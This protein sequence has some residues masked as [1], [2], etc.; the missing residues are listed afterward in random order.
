MFEAQL[1]YYLNRYIGAYVQGLDTQSLKISVFKGDVVLRNLKLKPEALADLNLPIT[2][3]AG[4]LGSLTLKVPWANLGRSPVII[5]IDRLYILAGPKTEVSSCEEEQYE[6]EELEREA[7]RR[8]V[9]HAE[10]TALQ[11]KSDDQKGGGGGMFKGLIDTIIGNLQLSIS[12]IHVRYEDDTSNPGTTFAVGLTLESLRAHTVDESG[13]EAFVTQNPMKLLRK[14]SELRRL[15]LY[16]D[17]GTKLW[18]PEE[19]WHKLSLNAWDALFRAGIAEDPAVN[20]DGMG[21]IEEHGGPGSAPASYVL[22]PVD[23]RLMYLRRGREVR[24]SEDDAIQEAD[25]QLE[26]LSLHLSRSQYQSLQKLLEA[27]SSLSARA[28]NRYLRPSGRPDSPANVRR[29]WQY[30]GAVVR[31]QIRSQGFNWRQFEKAIELR[32]AY[33]SQYVNCLQEGKMGGDEKIWDMDAQLN[34]HTTLVFRKLAHAKVEMAKKRAA[35]QAAAQARER[36]S[37]KGWLSWAWGGGG[38]K[39]GSKTDEEAH[40]DEDM[41]GGLNDEEQEALRDLVSEQED[42]LVSETETPWSLRM[43]VRLRVTSASL[44]LDG[45][46]NSQVMRAGMEGLSSTTKLYP[47]TMH[48]DIEVAAMGV[49]APE[50][51]LVRTGALL[52]PSKSTLGLP[53]SGEE[54]QEPFSKGQA[55]RL[56]FIQHPQDESTDA[57]V[58]LNLAPSYVTYNPVAVQ[59][60]MEFFKTEE[61]LDFSALG[62]Q[63]IAQVER[64][65]RAARDQLVA[66]MNHRPKLSVKLEL[67]GPKVAIPVP[68]SDTEG[69]LTLVLDLGS[70][71]VESD[72][73]LIAQLPQEEAALYECLRLRSRDISAYVVD[74]EFSFQALEQAGVAELPEEEDAEI[75]PVTEAITLAV[76]Q[77]GGRALGGRAIFIP[78]LERCGTETTVQIARFP[79]PQLPSL[80]A[81]LSVPQLRFFISPARVRR[82]LRVLRAAMPGQGK[83]I[84]RTTAQWPTRWVALYR[85]SL[86]VLPK[87]DANAS[88]TIHN[89]WT[90]RRV[91]KL[92]E[93]ACGGAKHVLAICLPTVE[94]AHAVQDGSSFIL[95]FSSDSQMEEWR[96]QLQRSQRKMKE[97]AG[98]VDE[99]LEIDFDVSAVESETASTTVDGA[100]AQ[101][102]EAGPKAELPGF[103]VRLAADLGEFALFVSGRTA[104]VWWP[105][106]EDGAPD[107]A[108]D[109]TAFASPVPG[110]KLTDSSAVVNVEGEQ[111][112]IVIRASSGSTDLS[113]GGGHFSTSLAVGAFEIEDL[114]VGKRCPDHG[115]LARSFVVTRVVDNEG[116]EFYDASA[117]PSSPTFLSRAASKGSGRLPFSDS[118]SVASREGSFKDAPGPSELWRS[119]DQGST[120]EVPTPNKKSAWVLDFDTWAQ[121]S[122][123]YAGVDA[124][125]RMRLKTLYFYANRPTIGALMGIGGD[126]AAAFKS[127]QAEAAPAAT[128]QTADTPF[129]MAAGSRSGTNLQSAASSVADEDRRDVEASDDLNADTAS[130]LA[131]S[132][133]RSESGD[134]DGGNL[135]MEGGSERVVFRLLVE[136]ER[137]EASL[138]YE[139]CSAPP[140]LLAAIEDVHF[141]LSVHPGTLLINA[142]LGNMRAQDGALPEGHPYRNICDLRHG[143]STSLIELEFAS[144]TGADADT[145]PR[146]PSGLP[147]YTLTAQLRE[148]EL[149]FLNRFL[150]E[151]LRYIMLLLA[152][153]PPPLSPPGL[154]DTNSASEDRATSTGKAKKGKPDKGVGFLLLLDVE[155][156]APVITIPRNTDSLDALEV[157]LGTFTLSN[158]IAWIGG[159]GNAS[160]RKAVL[161]EE[162]TI[163]LS[164]LSA[165]MAHDGERGNNM[166]REFDTGLSV[167]MQRPIRDLLQC[168]PKFQVGINIPSIKATLSDS[169]YRFIT[170]VAGSNFGEPLRLPA[171]AQWLEDALIDEPMED[172]ESEP[173]PSLQVSR[174]AETAIGRQGSV[175]AGKPA[176]ATSS[177]KSDRTAIRVVI[178]LGKSELEM[179]RTSNAATGALSPLARFTI[180]NLWVA[181]R[182]TAGGA[183]YLSVSLPRVEGVDLR[184]WVP[185]EHSLVISSEQYSAESRAEG[186]GSGDGSALAWEAAS[187]L[188]LEYKAAAQMS[189]QQIR[190]RLQRPTISAEMSFLLAVV[191]FY[192]PDFAIGSITPVPF[193]TQDILLTEHGYKPT[194]DLWLSPQTRLLADSPDGTD[195]VYDGQG[196][197]LILPEGISDGEAMPVIIVGAGKTLLLRDVKIVHAESLP[198]C[199]QLGSGGQL[200]ANPENKVQRIE[201]EDPTLASSPGNKHHL[202]RLGSPF[203]ASPSAR[204][205][206]LGKAISRGSRGFS[207]LGQTRRSGSIGRSGSVDEA[208][209]RPKQVNLEMEVVAVGVGLRFLELEEGKQERDAMRL[210]TPKTEAAPRAP[211]N[212]SRS[213]RMLAAYMDLGA[214]YKIA[215]DRQRASAELRGLHVETQVDVGGHKGGDDGNK[216]HGTVLEPCKVGVMMELSGGSGDIQMKLSD[217]RMNLSPDV[218][219]LAM[220]LQASV[221]EP[222]V[223]PAPDK[224][225]ARCTRFLQLWSNHPEKSGPAGAVMDTSVLAA[226][227]GLTFWRP[228]PPIGYA[229]LGDCVTTGTMQPTFQVV[230]VAVNSGLVSYPVSYKAA[231]QTSGLTIWEPVPPKGYVALGCLAAPG[232]EPPALTEMVTVHASIGVEAPLG[233]C[234]VLKEEKSWSPEAGSPAGPFLDLRSPLGITPAALKLPQPASPVVTPESSPP[235]KPRRNS[236]S[237]PIPLGKGLVR[238]GPTTQSAA[239]SLK[240]RPA[241]Y[242]CYEEFQRNRAKQLK[243]A[244]QRRLQS[245]AVD[246][247][248]VWWDKDARY[249][250]KTGLSFWRPIPPQGYISLGDCAEVGYD[251]P[252]SIVVLLDSELAE[253][254]HTSTPLVRPPRGFELLWH[255]ESDRADRCLSIWRPV[256]FPGYIAMGFVVGRGPHPPSRNAMRCMRANE[257]ATVD[258]RGTRASACLPQ[259][260]RRTGFSVWTGDERLSTFVVSA[261]GTPP[262]NKELQRLKILDSREPR[263]AEGPV[264]A[265]KGGMNIVLKT[266][267]TS[268]LLRDALRRP[269]AEIE[270][271][272]VDASVRRID[273]NVTRAYMGVLTSAWSYNAVIQAWEP[274]LEPWKLIVKMDMNTSGIMAHGVAPGANVSVK[275]T[276]ELM[277]ITLAYAAVQSVF[278]A[279]RQ[280]R[281]LHASGSDEAYKRQL[282]AADAASVHTHV[283]NTLGVAAEMQLDFGSHVE[284]AVLQSGKSTAVLQPLPRPPQRHSQRLAIPATAQ[285]PVLLV[286][287]VA[288]ASGLAAVLGDAAGRGVS[289]PD[290]YLNLTLQSGVEAGSVTSTADSWGART[291]AVSVNT[292]GREKEVIETRTAQP[293]SEAAVPEGEVGSSEEAA[294]VDWEEVQWNERLIL[295]LPPDAEQEEVTVELELWDTAGHRAMGVKIASATAAL[296]LAMFK[297]FAAQ[298]ATIDLC[299]QDGKAAK[300]QLQWAVVPQYKQEHA[301]T[302]DAWS[303]GKSTAGQRALR[304]AGAEDWAPVYTSA[305]TLVNSSSQALKKGARSSDDTASSVVPVRM[306]GAVVALES[307]FQG[308]VK[309]EVL[310]S[311]CQL[312][313]DTQLRLEVALVGDSSRSRSSSAS[314]S[315]GFGRQESMRESQSDAKEEEI[316]ENERFL[317]IKGWG[318]SLPT[319]RKRYSTRDGS[320]S[321]AE[322]PSLPLPQGWEWEGPWGSEDWAYGADWSTIT[323]PPHPNSLK[324]GMMDF[325]RRRRWVRRRRKQAISASS[326]AADL[327]S[328]PSVGALAE[329]ASAAQDRDARQVLGIAE[330]GDSLPVPHGWRSSGK[331]LVVRPILEGFPDAH[332]W[333][334]GGSDGAHSVRLDTLDEGQTRLLACAPSSPSQPE[335]GDRSRAA[336]A[337]AVARRSGDGGAAELAAATVWISATVEAEQLPGVSRSETLTDWRIVVAPPLVL[338]NQLPLRGSFLVWERPKEGENLMLRQSGV[339]ASGERRHIYAA[340]MRREVSLQFYPDGFEWV[341]SDPLPLSLGYSSHR[342]GLDGDQ[343]LQDSFHVAR[344]TGSEAPQAIY[345]NRELDMD[346]WQLADKK[347]D[348]GAAVALGAPLYVRMFVPLWVVNATSL[349][350]AA[351]VV[352]VQPPRQ[353]SEHEGQAGDKL[354]DAAESIRLKVLETDA[355]DG[356]PA[357]G[358][359]SRSGMPQGARHVLAGSVSMVAYPMQQMA[360]FRRNGGHQSYGLRLK[361]GE[362]GWTAPL[363]LESGTG[364]E[365]PDDINT[366]PV[367]IRARIPEW[368]TVHEIVAR[369]ELVG[370]GFERTLAL[371]L[372]PQLVITNH[373]G[374][375]LQLAQ[376]HRGGYTQSIA[377]VTP[378]PATLSGLPRAAVPPAGRGRGAFAPGAPGLRATVA[379]SDADVTSTLDLPTGGTGIPLHWSLQ[380]DSRAVCFRFAPE[381]PNEPGPQWSHPIELEKA[382]NTTARFVSLPGLEKIQ[383]LPQK[384]QGSY[385]RDVTTLQTAAAPPWDL[386]GLQIRVGRRVRHYTRAQESGGV[387][388]EVEVV[389]LRF[390]NELRAPGCMHVILECVSPRAPYLLENRSGQA[391]RYRQSGISDLPYIPLPAFSAASFAWQKENG[392]GTPRIEVCSA[393][394]NNTPGTCCELDPQ[395]QPRMAEDTGAAPSGSGAQR[396][397]LPSGTELQIAISD[398]EQE[399]MGAAGLLTIGGSA[400]VG[401]GTLERVLRVLPVSKGSQALA[402]TGAAAAAEDGGRHALHVNLDIG[403]L[404][405][406]VVDQRPEELIAAAVLGVR[407]Q[408]AAGLGPLGNCSSLRFSVDSMQF[409]NQIFGS[410]F[411][412]VMC[413]LGGE[414]GSEGNSGS[415]AQPLLQVTVVKQTGGPRGQIYYP[416]LSFRVA[417]TLQAAIAE[418]LVWR[419]VEMVQRLDLGALSDGSGEKHVATATDTPVQISLV[420]AADLSAAVSFRGDPF[421]RPRWASHMGVMSWLLDMANFEGI[422]VRLR[423]FEMQN[424]SMLWSAFIAQIIRQIKGQVAGV[425]LSFITNFGVFSGASGVLGALSRGVASLGT[426]NKTAEE[427]AAARQQRSIGN[428]GEGFAEGGDALAQGFYRGFTGLVTKP[429]QGARTGVGG[430]V[431][432]L[433]QGL[434]GVAAQPVSGALDFMSS[435]F[436]GID[437]SSNTILGKLSNTPRA[438]R[439]RRLPRSIGGDRKLQ[440]FVRAGTDAQARMEEVGQALM[441]RAV[442]AAPG[443]PRLGK[444]RRPGQA[445]TDAYEEHML[446]LDERVA[447]MTNQRLMLL[448]APGFQRIH[449]AAKEGVAPGN[450]D[451]IPVAEIRWSVEWQDLL[452]LE[453]RRTHKELPFYDRITVHRKGVPGHEED[454]PLAHELRCFPNESQADELRDI[455]L[456]VRDKFCVEP[457][458]ESAKWA[459][460]HR[461]DLAA[462]LPGLPPQALPFTMPSLDFRLVWHTGRMTDNGMISVW[463]VVA[464]PGY[465]ALGDV[466]SVGLDP[467]NAP[468]Q[469]YRNDSSEKRT[470][471][472]PRLAH[473]VDF[474]LVFRMNG[475]TPVTMWMP[476]APEGYVAL[477]T[478]VQG[479]PMMPDTSEVLCLRADLAA[480]TRFFDSPIWRRDP[481]ALQGAARPWQL[482]GWDILYWCYIFMCNPK[483]GGLNLQRMHKWDPQTWHCTVWQVDNPAG[484]FIAHHDTR[485]PPNSAALTLNL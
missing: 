118:D 252:Q 394:G 347:L 76:Q 67:V 407:V 275:S 333:S 198:A 59:R 3:K 377:G 331:Q 295:E 355:G 141:N 137:L 311:L 6:A 417:R 54:E 361:V 90:N 435:A 66:A 323:Y 188:T 131:P 332:L 304:L 300:L 318:N 328:A 100:K 357:A 23:G 391:L 169:E 58:Y 41:R 273:G 482:R 117:E 386:H 449:E 375:P 150:Q 383:P 24:K 35:A 317:P 254:E 155:M 234:L 480:A 5:T 471:E 469:V 270:L 434:V 40:E 11:D 344:A 335:T 363:P 101:T 432:G 433:G 63:A 62:A 301:V 97:L 399:I 447:L 211:G 192:L 36:Q 446:L 266:G 179:L 132:T 299:G 339:M 440:P 297:P 209:P 92:P 359:R 194:S 98:G 191:K 215:G 245:T 222:L 364:E 74:G 462:P 403:S 423:G 413:P 125:M 81:Q 291:R 405:V 153:Q 366:K 104:D 256:P 133:M 354:L 338:D 229:S 136:M 261:V 9:D 108:S 86:Y 193:Y 427:R 321:A 112:L 247:R 285:P 26:A 4:L 167:T 47:Q 485:P 230:S 257:A 393:S 430:F 161:Y 82:V 95:R 284:T 162:D 410:R 269:L 461:P 159:E 186:E 102:K 463:R 142:N 412:V 262:R 33:V 320:Q 382:L 459:R 78:L 196:H 342:A 425:A 146:V 278:R 60:V 448:H 110:H 107:G 443:L 327:A 235:E 473:A 1:A 135:V 27:F 288:C 182:T 190:V 148:L 145:S 356:A 91:V 123:G 286:A 484:T 22:K 441:W 475:R 396:L 258:L 214:S 130:T 251:P 73:G 163:V 173:A 217:L 438:V 122:S 274:I 140:L 267:A 28:P 389:V 49:I 56:Q 236:T 313:N 460:R 272:E 201:G 120:A 287:N 255:D 32:K 263:P 426:D 319:E 450:E 420:S 48:L 147:F 290:L 483:Q 175:P 93:D 220:S 307:S 164:G 181:F 183:L 306:R 453:L 227:R 85:G 17:V 268:L 51:N 213:V 25:V 280:W 138:N 458:R 341:D 29:W 402:L 129:A 415:A 16:F 176:R 314:S 8:R 325:V 343:K 44:V 160:D 431:K 457:Q 143:A 281:E 204:S 374:I 418:G 349:P 166:I 358:S 13:K 336:A 452:A 477:G 210:S 46:D 219:E 218:L 439:R 237:T 437:A 362:S 289:K 151:L 326:S 31:K 340:D 203:G 185:P 472:Q 365:G 202:Y 481:P 419:L 77:S 83:G 248:R 353:S 212:A 390:R 30:A 178:N 106:D 205:R 352:P 293:G 310:R 309:R 158:R 312:V 19:D 195:F 370:G 238:S 134:V 271:G 71:S 216:V 351:L 398:R 392:N 221:L 378:N 345:V 126:L 282:A 369:L 242:R 2:V 468:V 61:V 404:E 479:A 174:S 70:F 124:E 105:D 199:L 334:I 385:L 337:A 187:F 416:Y 409:D 87:E 373:T 197:R 243:T 50:G 478:I 388:E 127:G 296:D 264:Q 279:L 116:D 464:P 208:S 455:A 442:E 348:P 372:E 84:S 231:Y 249:P 88:P 39:S 376:L 283:L 400:G 171:A 64:A 467:P 414:S 408:Y 298:P 436:E 232:D 476:V 10:L 381:G 397:S 52:H 57:A 43:Q 121:T 395:V 315:R 152:M 223:Q 154:A 456:K 99:G 292:L 113:M 55:M 429:L 96:T 170:S 421:S 180:G 424:I 379:S 346:V 172:A 79:H 241:S 14:A 103:S 371:R 233:S 368:G 165:V 250:S 360:A 68:K 18:E 149:V 177:A 156:N 324:R 316:F 259:A 322:F 454:E 444:R 37:E 246:F 422:P 240:D 411:P 367:L 260:G 466:V 157:D 401:R 184:P 21:T 276:S 72:T 53:G 406:S 34:E 109:D 470:G 330:P 224:P 15:A 465:G 12:N 225:L 139:S 42:A 451:D 189:K 329:A 445:A 384:K 207:G 7:K 244:S 474:R 305:Q 20:G 200:V 128:P 114:L 253:M 115:Y 89:I 294:S 94:V 168:L 308:G 75:S 428:V 80:R 350:V 387:I 206:S 111:S 144:H 226:E 228:Q 265:P 277:R 45:A 239:A 302:T 119:Q 380:A 65:Q 69:E 303:A 38:K